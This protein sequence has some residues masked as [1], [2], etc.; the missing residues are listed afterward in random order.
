MENRCVSCDAVIPE[1]KQV[2]R[3]C[4]EK[5]KGTE[6]GVE[7]KNAKSFLGKEGNVNDS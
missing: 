1:G 5:E 4:T 7:G 2:C 6:T 3:N